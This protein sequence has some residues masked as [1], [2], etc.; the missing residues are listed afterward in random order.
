[1]QHTSTVTLVE[2][3]LGSMELLLS[4]FVLGTKDIQ[5]QCEMALKPMK[6]SLVHDDHNILI[7]IICLAPG[8]HPAF[9]AVC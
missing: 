7:R 1:M 6:P 9:R 3:Y 8:L 2:H 4:E 5:E